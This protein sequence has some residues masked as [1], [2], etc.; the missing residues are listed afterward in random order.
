[1]AWAAGLADGSAAGLGFVDALP[2]IAEAETGFAAFFAALV[3]A[4]E[5]ASAL[6]SLVTALPLPALTGLLALLLDFVLT[7]T[8]THQKGFNPS[9]LGQ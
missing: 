9:K 8:K 4:V 7:I 6:L 5:M 3:L 2:A 1:M